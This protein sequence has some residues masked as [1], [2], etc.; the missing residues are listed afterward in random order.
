MK[1]TH[2]DG[3]PMTY[4]PPLFG[5]E[6]MLNFDVTSLPGVG[7]YLMF[8]GMMLTVVASYFGW[9]TS[10]SWVTEESNEVVAT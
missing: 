5:N 3:T 7:G 9:K 2:P 6:K 10:K 1:L 8:L 4:K